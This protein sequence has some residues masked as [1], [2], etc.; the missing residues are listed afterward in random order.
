[1]ILRS[2]W[3]NW[4][5]QSSQR[6]TR[7][8]L[9]VVRVVPVKWVAVVGMS[10]MITSCGASWHLKRAIAKDPSIIKPKVVEI[11]TMVVVEEKTLVDTL[12]ITQTD[13]VVRTIENDEGVKIKLQRIHDTIRVDVFCPPDTVHIVETYEIPQVVV[14]KR[15]HY[16]ELLIIIVLF[17]L[18]I[19][20]LRIFDMIN[21]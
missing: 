1:M 8:I 15:N 18:L 12:V 7:M 3:K 4:R 9:R 19:A 10:M 17:V 13:T 14:P 2:G 6:A 21:K 20:F 16:K 11:D 5:V